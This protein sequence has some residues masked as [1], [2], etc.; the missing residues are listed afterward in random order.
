MVVWKMTSID[1]PC[2]L[3][4]AEKLDTFGD[5]LIGSYELIS[6]LKKFQRSSCLFEKSNIISKISEKFAYFRC[7]RRARRQYGKKFYSAM[8]P[9]TSGIIPSFRLWSGIFTFFDFQTCVPLGPHPL[10]SSLTHLNLTDV[11]QLANSDTSGHVPVNHFYHI[12]MI[13]HH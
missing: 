1:N 4:G 11:L 10:W 3:N 5:G 2:S 7:H 13:S 6:A 9:E 12:Q 8:S